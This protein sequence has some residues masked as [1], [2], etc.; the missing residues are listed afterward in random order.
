M[1]GTTVRPPRPLLLL[2]VYGAFLAI[3]G[4]SAAAQRDR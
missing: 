1:F 3:V 4:I 2:I